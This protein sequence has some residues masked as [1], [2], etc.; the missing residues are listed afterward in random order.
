VLVDG[1]V[2]YGNDVIKARA[3]GAD[4]VMIGRPWAWAL[5]AQGEQGVRNMLSSLDN[6]VRNTL[7]LMGHARLNDLTRDSLLPAR[8]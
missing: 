6:E 7:G 8:T 1:G 3:L 4:G 2:R 5:A